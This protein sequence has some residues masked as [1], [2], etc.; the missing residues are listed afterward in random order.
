MA[1]RTRNSG[2]TG[3]QID[4]NSIESNTYSEKA[5]AR[6]NIPAGWCLGKILGDISGGYELQPGVN[7]ALYNNSSSVAFADFYT[8]GQSF[9][10]SATTA[11]AIPPNSYVYI[12]SGLLN[13]IK[14]SA[15]TVLAYQMDDETNYSL[16]Q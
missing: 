7:I 14:S 9:T 2:N 10:P 6:K 16:K 15:A 8:F 11:R 12:N 5:G 13:G 1:K 4:L 3:S